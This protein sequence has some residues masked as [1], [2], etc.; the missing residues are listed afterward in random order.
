MK[1][2]ELGGLPMPSIAIIKAQ[3]GHSEYG[4]VSIV[5]PSDTIDPAMSSENKIY[6][7][8]AWT[9]VYPNI[10][11]K[12]NDEVQQKI[13]KLYYDIYEKYGRDEARP[14]KK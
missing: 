13:S 1:S 11:Y 5:F 7:G 12:V 3:R 2:L 8:D 4:D 9:P 6:G 10:E 14:W